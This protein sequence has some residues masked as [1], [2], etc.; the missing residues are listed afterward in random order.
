MISKKLGVA[1]LC[2]FLLAYFG[3]GFLG[4]GDDLLTQWTQSITVSRLLLGG[5]LCV[6]VVLLTMELSDNDIVV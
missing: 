3:L 5:L 2:I 1:A 4:Y 6:S